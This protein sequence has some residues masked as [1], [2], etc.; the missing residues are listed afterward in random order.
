MLKR[1]SA[2]LPRPFIGGKDV[3]STNDVRKTD[4]TCER[5]KLDPY[6]HHTQNYQSTE[7][8]N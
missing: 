8:K 7:Y 1:S 2:R 4:S 3:F 5:I 6:L